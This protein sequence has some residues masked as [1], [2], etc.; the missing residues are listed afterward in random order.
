MKPLTQRTLIMIITVLT[1]GFTFQSTTFAHS[2]DANT[3][4]KIETPAIVGEEYEV[5]GKGD[6]D[7]NE[8]PGEW[9]VGE[10]PKNLVE[11]APVLLFVHGLNSKAQVWW[12]DDMYD[13]AFDAGYETAFIQLYDAGGESASMWDN[14]ALLAEK[15]EDISNHFD[16]K[17][18]TIIAHSK[19]GVDSQTAL[20]HYD[21]WQYVDNV[22][23]LG[24]PHRGSHLADLAYSSWAG[25]LAELIG[26]KGD[27]TESMQMGYMEHFRS[28]TDGHP[29]MNN[30][31]YYTMGGTGSGSAFSANWF[32]S[33]YL[34]G[35][36]KNDGVVTLASSRLPGATEIGVDN[37]DHT[38]I[39][40]GVTFPIFKSY[41]TGEATSNNTTQLNNYTD[42]KNTPDTNQLVRGG[43]LTSDGL[44]KISIPIESDMKELT[45]SLLTADDLGSA[46]LI[47]PTGKVVHPRVELA[48]DENEYF[49]GATSYQLTV[50]GAQAGEWVLELHSK[51]ESAYLLTVNYDTAEKIQLHKDES[52]KQATYQVSPDLTQIDSKSL[53]TTYRVTSTTNPTES[54]TWTV[55]GN[56]SLS[57]DFTFNKNELYNITIDIE[58][59]TKSGNKFA[60]TIIDSVYTE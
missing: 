24:S 59:E 49:M 6:N 31:N 41:I 56:E 50:P 11:D 51:T 45:L 20:T 42:V 33:I 17:D 37:W 18:I 48:T 40:T 30:N 58:G 27:G 19:G 36:G 8:T 54:S 55:Q 4:T 39:R 46:T 29:S 15:I 2:K 34:S 13:T 60:R 9:Y 47:D 5:L 23:T 12:E 7:N 57:Q 25:W 38:A 35:Y 1:L 28:E 52:S 53:Q 44:E 22:I 3:A 43:P 16:G 10:T 32:G 21:A 14:G 26:M